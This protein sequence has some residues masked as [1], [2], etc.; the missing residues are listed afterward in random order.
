MLQVRPMLAPMGAS[1][2]SDA[3]CYLRHFCTAPPTGERPVLTDTRIQG[4]G[5]SPFSRLSSISKG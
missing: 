5:N 2:Y 1:S 3:K 4:C